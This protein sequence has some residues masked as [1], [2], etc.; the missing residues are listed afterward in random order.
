MTF[1]VIRSTEALL[2]LEPEWV[3]LWEQCEDCTPFQHPD[4]LLAWWRHFGAGKRLHTVALWEDG[5]LTGLLPLCVIDEQNGAKIVPVGIGL[6]DYLDVLALPGQANRVADGVLQRLFHDRDEWV[7]CDLQPLLEGSPLIKAAA[8][9]G[10]SS[11][12]FPADTL[13]SVDLPELWERFS[14]T[15]SRHFLERMEDAARHANELGQVRFAQST[16][17]TLESDMDQL[18]RFRAQ[19]WQSGD[20]TYS[21]F[22]RETARALLGRGALRLLTLHVNEHLAAALYGFVH[23]KR[24]YFYMMGFDQSYARISPGTLL[25]SYGL[26]MFI[27]EGVTTCDLLR[28]REPFKYRWGA[29]ERSSHCRRLLHGT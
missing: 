5:L 22:C 26:E 16:A 24:G 15:L 25:M 2:K 20:P 7:T 4:W 14:A 18:L 19:R 10:L 17:V 13:T 3:A 29:V 9:E 11:Q 27:A 12:I 21:D 23:R 28:G 6:S 1:E 8:P